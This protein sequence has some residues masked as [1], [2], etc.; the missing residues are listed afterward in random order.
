MSHTVTVKAVEVRNDAALRVACERIGVD[1]PRVGIHRLFDGT[2]RHGHAVK[3]KGWREDVVFDLEK[4]ECLFDNYGG[5][6]GEEDK[7]D[8]LI[9]SYTLEASK[10]EAAAHN[11]GNFTEETQEDGSIKLRMEQ[12]A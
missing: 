7:L 11:Y 9:Q 3:L 8:E 12:Y 1:A 4:G 2:Q 5:R 10:I 6:W